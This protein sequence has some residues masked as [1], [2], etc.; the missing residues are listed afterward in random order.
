MG[1]SLGFAGFGWGVLRMMRDPG[2]ADAWLGACMA[3]EFIH[4]EGWQLAFNA[5]AQG[6]EKGS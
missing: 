5:V 1:K 4:L 2:F 3:P 6:I